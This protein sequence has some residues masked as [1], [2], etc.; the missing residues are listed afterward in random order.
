MKF[1]NPRTLTPDEEALLTKQKEV[2]PFKKNKLEVDAKKNWDL[3][4]KRNGTNFF[5]DR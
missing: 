5:K 1:E 3:F 2:K 4:Y